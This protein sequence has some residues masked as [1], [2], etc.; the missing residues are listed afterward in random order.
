M[1]DWKDDLANLLADVATSTP[2]QAVGGILG[3]APVQGAF[4]VLNAPLAATQYLTGGLIG[5]INE[6]LG[7]LPGKPGYEAAT[8]RA[9]HHGDIAGAPRR[10]WDQVRSEEPLWFQ[11]PTE[12]LMDPTTYTGLGLFGKGAEARRAAQAVALAEGN[13]GKANRLGALARAGEATQWLNDA[14]G[15]AILEGGTLPQVLGGAHVPGVQAGVRKLSEPLRNTAGT[16]LLDLSPKSQLKQE[17][18]QV[19]NAMSDARASNVGI[20]PIGTN[21][22]IPAPLSRIDGTWLHPGLTFEQNNLM[23]RQLKD[24]TTYGTFLHANSQAATDAANQLRASGVT[25]DAD[26]RKLDDWL[27]A[28]RGK[29]NEAANEKIVREWHKKGIDILHVDAGDDVAA[30]LL[31]GQLKKERDIRESGRSYL[32]SLLK[33]AWGEQALF[34]G[35]YHTGNIQ[36]NVM[37]SLAAGHLDW[38][39]VNPATYIRNFKIFNA[40]ENTIKRDRMLEGL[41]VTQ[42]AKKYGQERAP[43]NVFG[44]GIQDFINSPYESA[45][46]T[47]AGKVTGSDRVAR[48]VGKPFVWNNRIALGVDL[49]PRD[50]IYSDVKELVMSEGLPG[51]EAA[52]REKLPLGTDFKTFGAPTSPP[53]LA[54]GDLQRHLE[55]IGVNRGDADNLTRKFVELRGKADDA[56]LKE[57]HKVQFDYLKTNLDEQVGKFAPFHYWYSRALRFWGEA[58]LRNPY[59][60]TNYM[61]ANRGLE[62]AQHDPGLNARQKGFLRLMGTP[63]GFSLMMN[64]DALFG[65]VKVFGMEQAN[66]PNVDP[67]SPWNKPPE[68]MT[69]L[70]GVMDWMKNRGVGLYPWMDGLLNMMGAYGNTFEPD[71][72]GIRHRALVGSAVNWAVS[73]AGGQMPGTPYANAMGQAR[74]ALSSTASQ[75]LPGWLAQPV[76]PK[77]GGS[78]Q[79]ASL[80]TIIE[81]TILTDNPGLSGEQ[82]LEIMS[83]PDSPEY[84]AAYQKAA[85]AGVVQQ[86][87]NFTL[88][89][90]VAMRNDARDVRT[91]QKRV[92]EDAATKAGVTPF[93]FAPTIGDVQFAADYKR[94]TGSDWKPGD[95]ADASFKIDLA[96]APEGS[97]R[98]IFEDAA[99]KELGTDTQ[100]QAWDTYNALKYGT[101]PGT[102]GLPQESRDQLANAWLDRTGNAGNIRAI[103]DQRDAFALRHPDYAAY[104]NWKDQMQTIQG[105][106]GNLAE[107]RRQASAQNPNAARYFTERQ[108]FLQRTE[109]DPEKY[110]EKLEQVTMSPSAYLAIIGQGEYRSQPGGIP[111]A[112]RFDTALP[113]ML[114]PAQPQEPYNPQ[115]NWMAQLARYGQSQGIYTPWR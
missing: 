76:A 104:L 33:S 84:E 51:W 111:G 49:V 32:G 63:L 71:L 103:Y 68:G 93:Q 80:E 56:A 87:L 42:Q 110:Q 22:V 70:G 47:I 58:A 74:W 77:A 23:A 8:S 16:G 109:S 64:P 55:S 38:S 18:D 67:N 102:A 101:A 2:G 50:A 1:T 62:D 79:Q 26:N 17:M 48:V 99:Y 36:S 27:A 89:M 5:G 40:G 88:P 61:R 54:A 52:V 12:V 100:K 31:E 7:L 29:P 39:Q 82:L 15:K 45:I 13:I 57:M 59:L 73:Q 96:R 9:L 107:Y 81:H 92:I 14:P 20:I 105:M 6:G 106:Y 113:G 85:S 91:A 28:V 46:G 114:P 44:G 3:S 53:S 34:S 75:F 90:S 108:A 60:M 4:T 98:F 86:L 69:D 19:Y 43:V 97:K 10:V 95:Y 35:R 11:A 37:M 30:H 41:K 112:P 115:E 66:D 94:L 78:T 65:V 83:D 24:G 72:L 21:T 25:W